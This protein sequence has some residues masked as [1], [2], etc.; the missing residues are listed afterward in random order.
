MNRLIKILIFWICYQFSIS[1]VMAQENLRFSNYNYNRLFYN[2]AYAGTS[3]FMEAVIAYRNQWVG[4]EGSPETALVSVQAPVNYTNFG[5]GA[6]F[7]NNKFGIQQDN[8]IFLNYAYHFQV[9]YNGILS[10]GVQAG[11]VNKQI[12]WTNLTRFDPNFPSPNDPAFPSQDISTWVSNFGI[13]LY[14]YTPEYF[15]S[16]SAPRLLSNNQPS[17]EGLS[18]NLTFDV[19]Q[20]HFFLGAGINLPINNEINFVPSLLL[21]SSYSSSTNMNM[22]F[23]FIHESGVSI[24]MGYR[25]D[26]SWAALIGYQLNP[27]LRFSYSYEKSFGKY[28]SKGFTNHE[29][30][31]NYNLSLKKS[32][33]TSPRY[34]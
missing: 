12:K 11:F 21:T 20:I 32:Q 8:A 26:D 16:F 22:N 4:I 7:Y 15:I 17:T 2:P 28:R 5:L 1:S 30:I 25:S 6:I 18:N 14:Y 27:K 13:G 31:L 19:K 9:S 3:R 34:F 33:I 23:D 24:G 10:L 29:I